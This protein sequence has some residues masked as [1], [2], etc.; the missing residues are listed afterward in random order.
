MSSYYFSCMRQSPTADIERKEFIGLQGGDV[1]GLYSA[2]EYFNTAYNGCNV[3]S[4][5]TDKLSAL[6]H[7]ELQYSRSDAANYMDTR[8]LPQYQQQ[9]HQQSMRAGGP[10]AGQVPITPTVS[11]RRQSTT[12]PPSTA[13]GHQMT[14]LPAPTPVARHDGMSPL[15][16]ALSPPLSTPDDDT[17]NCSTDNEQ[18]HSDDKSSNSSKSLQSPTS[19]PVSTNNTASST[20]SPSEP[21]IYP[22]MRRVHSGHNSGQNLRIVFSLCSRCL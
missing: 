16:S 11:A 10:V 15:S 6:R 13:P 2:A 7:H 4:P 20:L 1:S 3:Y 9:H 5:N 12:P 22:W 17:E 8:S 18:Q 14:T 19:G 21:T